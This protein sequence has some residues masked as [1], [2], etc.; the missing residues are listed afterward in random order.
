MDLTAIQAFLKLVEVGVP[1]ALTWRVGLWIV[2]TL[3]DWMTG[4]NDRI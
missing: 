1:Y 4:T 3:L 2:Q